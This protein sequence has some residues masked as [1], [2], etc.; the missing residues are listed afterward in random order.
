MIR[1]LGTVITPPLPA[2]GL[3]ATG[4]RVLAAG[5]ITGTVL[6]IVLGLHVTAM[7]PVQPGRQR[8]SEPR[9]A[10]CLRGHV[11]SGHNFR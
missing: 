1:E 11:Y 10:P 7:P 6:G 3:P 5:A 2:D 8:P 4:V 9:P